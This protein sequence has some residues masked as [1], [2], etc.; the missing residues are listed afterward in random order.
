MYRFKVAGMTCGGCASSVERA[1]KSVDPAA[2]FTADVGKRE[3]TV[4]SDIEEAR[5][6]D[7]IRSA[8]YENQKAA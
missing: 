7:A 3:V 8:G 1:V 4:R 6:A 2:H 5:F